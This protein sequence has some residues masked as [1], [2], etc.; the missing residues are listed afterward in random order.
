MQEKKCRAR[1][2]R[3]LFACLLRYRW[4][5]QTFRKLPDVLDTGKSADKIF[6]GRLLT[7]YVQDNFAVWKMEGK[8]SHGGSV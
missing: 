4:V 5:I 7:V 1:G 3:F 6:F 8:R 2:Q